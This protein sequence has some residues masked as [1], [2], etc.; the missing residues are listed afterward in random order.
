VDKARENNVSVDGMVIV[1]AGDKKED[2]MGGD[3]ERLTSAILAVTTGEKTKVFF[4]TGHGEFDPTE[5]GQD[6]VNDIKR[7][8]ESQ[9]YAVESFSMFNEAKPGIPDDA[10]AV[11]IAGAQ[12]PLKDAE[13]D[14][15]AK[16]ADQGGKLFIALSTAAGAPNFDRILS[17]R[18]VKPLPGAIMEPN[19]Q[20]NAGGPALP[21]V[22]KPEPHEVTAR[23]QGLVLPMAG[24]LEV[25]EAPEPP[26]SYPGAPPPPT[27]QK[28]VALL[29][30]SAEA[31]L[32][33]AAEGGKG[34]E[35][36][37]GEERT[38]PLVMAAAIDES[39]K[40][41]PPQ[42]PG[43]PPQPEEAGEGPGTRIVVVANA[44]FLTDRLI[45]SARLWANAAFALNSINWLVGNEK[46]ISIPPK[47]T[48]TPYLTMV[49]AQKAIAAVLT[50]FVVP[51]L[52]VIAGGLVWWRRRR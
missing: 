50:L 3:E 43:M 39:K 41:T 5:M 42:Q 2:V 45:E 15:L 37:D 12:H 40:E 16:Y 52:I 7:G 18:G 19:A 25:E 20:H 9:Q 32:D 36:R 35:T 14:A 24:A 34:N 11:I 23:L 51:G 8:L 21:A 30:T 10:A 48:E 4:L 13:M 17:S 38:G 29:K 49:G 33:A 47:E 22:L 1:K 27:N 28:A 44:E 6:S 46:L 31:W 26:P